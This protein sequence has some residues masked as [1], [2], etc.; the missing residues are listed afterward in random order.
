M[1]GKVLLVTAEMGLGHIRA[2][3]PLEKILRSEMLILG[4]SPYASKKAKRLWRRSL[5]I[6]EWFSRASQ[7]PIIGEFLFSFMKWLL[8]IEPRSFDSNQEKPTTQLRL[9]ERYIKKGLCDELSTVISGRSLPVVTSFYAPVSYM[10]MF[11][12]NTPTFCQLCDTDISRVWV[13]SAPN[14]GNIYYLAPTKDVFERLC[15]YGVDPSRIHITGFPIPL[16]LVG[17]KGQE[18]AIQNYEKRLSFLKST[19]VFSNNNPLRIAYVVGGAGAM[20]DIGL[21]AATSLLSQIKEGAVEFTIISSLC[22]K[23]S[24]KF[25]SF[26]KRFF[27]K[28]NGLRVI[29]GDNQDDYFEKFNTAIADTH[30]IW[31]KPSELTFYSSLGI[32]IIMAPPLGPQEDANRNWLLANNIGLDQG[33]PTQCGD[34][35]GDILESGL[36][37]PMAKNGWVVGNRL[38][39]YNIE[40]LVSSVLSQYN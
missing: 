6:Y 14:S 3:K 5:R 22:R 23:S 4:Q 7:W 31:T 13:P 35:V 2:L 8:L 27:G 39:A 15:S 26:K 17:S 38:A 28:V 36:L 20:V 40:K 21:K 30:I 34:W 12:A 1:D 11:R 9:L 16:E 37:W 32:P 10:A 24:S 25:K 18:I 29:C 19:R 33:N